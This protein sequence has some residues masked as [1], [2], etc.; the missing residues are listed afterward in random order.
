MK[1]SS[2]TIYN[3]EEA[4]KTIELV[5]EYPNDECPK[6]V[7]LELPY[8]NGRLATLDD[9]K[10][11]SNIDLTN[12]VTQ[13]EKKELVNNM[14]TLKGNQIVHDIKVFNSAPRSNRDAVDDDELVRLVQLQNLLKDADF[15]Y[16]NSEKMS[17]TVGGLTSGTSFDN[18]KLHD[19]LTALL[20]PYRE[21]VVSSIKLSKTEHPCYSFLPNINLSYVINNEKN[22]KPDTVS[23]HVNRA[24]YLTKQPTNATVSI[25]GKLGLNYYSTGVNSIPVEVKCMSIKNKNISKSVNLQFVLWCFTGCSDDPDIVVG[26]DPLSVIR[27]KKFN[28][29]YTNNLRQQFTFPQGGYKYV[30][31]PNTWSNPTKFIDVATQFEVPMDYMGETTFDFAPDGNDGVNPVSRLTYKV[32]RSHNVLGG[33]ITVKIQ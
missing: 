20:Y 24:E 2:K 12:Y 18:V 16:T 13:D 31:F 33:S 22:V 32:Y 21:P 28:I 5:A 11:A 25:N 29:K 27:D 8:K 1:T 17:E 26:G 23:V 10:N 19:L 7:T 6:K 4:N 3:I 30:V 14:V 15:S 9:V